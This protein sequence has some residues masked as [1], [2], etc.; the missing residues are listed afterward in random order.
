MTIVVL[1]LGEYHD[2]A[3]MAEAKVPRSFDGHIRRLMSSRGQRMR[4]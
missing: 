4:S 1:L 2:V 3:G